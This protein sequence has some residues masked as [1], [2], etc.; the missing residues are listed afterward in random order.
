MKKYNPEELIQKY[1]SG[2][3]TAEEKALVES[4]HLKELSESTHFP[5][6]EQINA[7]HQRMQSALAQH[8]QASRRKPV[9][10][11]LWFRVAAAALLI[12]IFFIGVVLY[13]VPSP[14]DTSTLTVQP[15]ILPGHD[16]ATLTLADGSKVVLDS[17]GNGLLTTQNGTK[18]VLNN[19]Q[20]TY[21]ADGATATAV[22][23]NTISTARGRQFK[24][25][26]PD[27]SQVWL[28]AASSLRYPTAFVGNE[29]NVEITGE[30]YFEVAKNEQIPFKVKA[31]GRME[32]QVLGTHFNVNAYEDEEAV[33]TTLLEGSVN[34]TAIE[35]TRYSPLTTRRLS[36]GQQAQLSNNQL[37]IINNTDIEAVVAW[38][39]GVFNF[40][41]ATLEKVMRQLARWYDIEIVY[42]KDIPDIAFEGEI[43][44]QNE[45]AD[46]L[47]SLERLGVH[48]KLEG[49]RLTVLP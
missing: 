12:G 4:W 14:T 20:L 6:E 28:N 33:R 45:L 35:P 9:T 10:R 39:N 43:N 2:N 5:A 21:Q 13:R 48:F 47:H 7:V 23:Y 32:I 17:L 15:V 22:V 40:Q 34:V 11:R 19:G 8:I 29:R 1:L 25:T 24:V 49:R 42:E 36:P 16:G 30:A 18:V 31:N 46:V 44:R 27:G 41:D 26:L 37:S 3:C 38:K